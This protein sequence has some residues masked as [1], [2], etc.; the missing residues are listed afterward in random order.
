MNAGGE[1]AVNATL[2]V[3]NVPKSAGNLLTA[4]A[5]SAKSSNTSQFSQC[6]SLT[7]GGTASSATLDA[8]HEHADDDSRAL[9]RTA[10]SDSRRARLRTRRSTRTA[11]RL[12]AARR[13]PLGAIP[14]GAIPSGAIPLGAIPLGAIGLTPQT[15]LQDGL[16]GVPLNTIPLNAPKSWETELQ[17]TTL[18][19]LPT[20]TLTLRDVLSLSTLPRDLQSG[21][22]N[23]ITL[24]DVDLSLSPLGAI[25]LGAIA[26]GRTPLG[27]IPISGDASSDRRNEL[28]HADPL[29]ARFLDV[30][31][32]EPRHANRCRP[33]AAGRAARCDSTRR[34]S[35]WRNPVGCD[36]ARCDPARCDRTRGHAARRDS[37]RRD[38]LP[39]RGAAR[40]DSARSHPA[41][42]DP[43]RCDPARCDSGA[44]GRRRLHVRLLLRQGRHSP[45]HSMRAQ[46]SRTRRSRISG[47][48]E[49]PCSATWRPSSPPISPRSI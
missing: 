35:A 15:L 47:P 4:T 26:L 38:R 17:S 29:A 40:R 43:A 44:L 41:W 30:R 3:S 14:L 37:A 1:A 7:Q 6:I 23:P 12:R 39:G 27:A 10:R 48:T 25:P 24:R 34:D 33:R 45:T 42:C 19:G 20:Q 36:S 9:L 22:T 21:A 31:L 13:H 11:A 46:S 49:A 32:H 5:T 18:A 28:V 8:A 2:D 16:G